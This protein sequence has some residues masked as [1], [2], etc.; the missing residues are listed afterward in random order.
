MCKKMVPLAGYL[1]TEGIYFLQV[2]LTTV[3]TD[4]DSAQLYFIFLIKILASTLILKKL[5]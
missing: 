3:K 2:F 1:L 4:Y 5:Y